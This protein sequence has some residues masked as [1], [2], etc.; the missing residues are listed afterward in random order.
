[1]AL[2][3]PLAPNLETFGRLCNAKMDWCKMDWAWRVQSGPRLSPPQR[4]VNQQGPWIS[5]HVAD[6]SS[7]RKTR[8]TLI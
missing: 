5:K 1:M 4:I 2:S 6:N 3:L 7:F 8:I